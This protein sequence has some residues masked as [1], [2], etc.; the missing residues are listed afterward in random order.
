MGGDSASCGFGSFLIPPFD[1]SFP[2]WPGSVGCSSG[3]FRGLGIFVE[4]SLSLDDLLCR[5]GGG[6]GLSSHRG[7]NSGFLSATKVRL[8]RFFGSP[9]LALD[10]APSVSAFEP[11]PTDIH[12]RAAG[13]CIGVA[14]VPTMPK[15]QI[16][17]STVRRCA[18][19]SF[20]RTR[21]EDSETVKTLHSR[22]GGGLSSHQ[23]KK[24]RSEG[25]GSEVTSLHLGSNAG[26]HLS[27]AQG[28]ADRVRARRPGPHHPRRCH[29]GRVTPPTELC[30]Q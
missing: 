22:D 11:A 18:R 29:L 20:E 1:P 10:P 5:E 27:P 3:F 24:T 25:G 6:S 9:L 12:A 21:S 26:L 14:A 2:R 4:F 30:P 13:S 17:H 16:I 15:N 8:V 28:W 23:P 7:F 19:S